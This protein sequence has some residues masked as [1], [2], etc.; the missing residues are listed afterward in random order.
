[1]TDILEDYMKLNVGTE[2]LTEAQ[3]DSQLENSNPDLFTRGPTAKDGAGHLKLNIRDK[4]AEAFVQSERLNDRQEQVDSAVKA[5]AHG[6]K[7]LAPI[8]QA[9]SAHGASPEDA[10]KIMQKVMTRTNA[11]TLRILKAYGLEEFEAPAWLSSTISGQVIKLITNSLEQGNTAVL[12][13]P[14]SDY[15][16]PLIESLKAAGSIGGAAH[17]SST[18]INEITNSLMMATCAVMAEFQCFSYFHSDA[19][20]MATDITTYFDDR[21]VRGT[22]AELT[23][24]FKLTPNEQSYFAN[25]ILSSAGE[26]MAQHWKNG[27]PDVIAELRGL[28]EDARQEVTANG[29]PLSNIIQRFEGSYQAIELASENAIRVLNPGREVLGS[30]H[31]PQRGQGLA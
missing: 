18:P 10:S 21:V 22:V 31:S 13:K 12:D 14:S 5:A 7:I 26:M 30:S 15:I 1:M 20:K 4:M 11:D 16:A 24:R 28:S 29:Y 27:I 17:P 25:S 3:M 9:V 23:E 19:G 8:L 2:S 6:V